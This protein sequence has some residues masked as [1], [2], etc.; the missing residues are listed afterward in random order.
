MKF[1]DL[2][3]EQKEAATFD[4]HNLLLLAGAGTGKTRTI[5]A[6]AKYLLEKG[7]RP[8][9]LLILSFTRKSA[10]EIVSR[11]QSSSNADTRALK[12]QTFHSWC[13]E[14]IEKNPGVFNF[15]KFTVI[16]EE[17]RESA[18]RLVCGRHFKKSNFIEPKQLAEVYSFVVNTR[19][20]LSTALAR[21]LFQ[22]RMDEETK[23]KILKKLPVYQEVIKKY[24]RF[25]AERRYL[26]YDD[27]LQKVAVGLKKN[28]EAAAF[29]AGGYDHILI[30]EMQ[31]TNPLQ[32]L[33]LESFWNRCNLFCVGDDAQSIYGFRGADFNSIHYFQLLVPNAQVK[34]LTI[35][36][37]ST[38]EILDLSNWVLEKSPLNYN[39]KL[40]A[41]RGSGEKPVISHYHQ[42]WDMARDIVMRI[43][44]SQGEENCQFKDNMVLSRSNR[45]LKS[46]EACLVEAQIPYVIY[47]GT[48]LMASA[49]V[50]DIVSALRVVANPRDE[51]A[52]E[53][54]LC[55]FPRIGEIT[56][57]KII[58]KLLDKENL[59]ECI[60]VLEDTKGLDSDIAVTLFNIKMLEIEVNRAIEAAM[61][62]LSKV[63]EHKYKEDWER[64]KKDITLLERIGRG[65]ES[66][67]AFLS[68]YV[69]DP[70]LSTGVKGE[71]DPEDCVVLTTIHSAKGLEAKNCYLINVNFTQYPSSRAVANGDDAIEEDRRCLY[72]AL[73]RAKDRLII[74]RTHKAA[75]VI[76]ATDVSSFEA[77]KLYFL[78]DLPD[79]LYDVE[80]LGSGSREWGFY[81]GEGIS[82]SECD[83]FDFS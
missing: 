17:D 48:S 81:R 45:G 57:A 74:Y 52:W 66:I 20:N 75:Q 11:L 33:L 2:N 59:E 70:S 44:N 19:C 43:K 39:K 15:G 64:R 8:S 80:N 22:G 32:Y 51:L 50:R 21:R 27:I 9:R 58:D 16:D 63:L 13:M 71:G 10:R 54:Y 24:M 53:R 83:E 29:I 42:E 18:F 36:Y 28:P 4:G 35:N 34:K 31:D 79:S 25:K 78:N 12:G 3:M 30:D 56:A 6:R 60:E 40:C 61:R 7:V 14:M 38:Q 23:E 49:H 72:V 47:G 68:D 69:L 65:S 67:T 82:L 62:G 73:T 77:S 37:R 55:L 76:D 46:V 41:H 1:D 26:D 5:I